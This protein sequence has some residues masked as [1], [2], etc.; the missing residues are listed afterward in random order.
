MPGIESGEVVESHI[1]AR[2]EGDNI[3]WRNHER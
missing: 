1:V 2:V 3:T